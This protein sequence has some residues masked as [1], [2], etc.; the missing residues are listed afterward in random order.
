MKRRIAIW[1]PACL[2][3]SVGT[4][5]ILFIMSD[6]MKDNRSSFLRQFPSHVV[7]EG[8]DYDLGYHS[9]YIAGGTLE[10]IYLGNY[11]S[12]LHL[13]MLNRNLTDTLHIRL[14]VEGVMEQKFWSARVRVDSPYFYMYDGAVPRIY[15]GNTADWTAHRIGYDNEYFLDLEPIG[16]GSFF[17][18]SL[19]LSDES[20]VGKISAGSPHYKFTTGILQKQVDG[21]FCTDGTVSYNNYLAQLVYVYRY[22][23]EFIVMDTN[24]N[25]AY[26]GNTI[27][28][29]THAKINVA[30]IA[31]TNARTFS[32]PPLVV[33][34]QSST[35]K[36]WLFVNSDLLAKNEHPDALKEASVIDVYDLRNSKYSFSFYLFNHLGTEK[37]REFRVVDGGLLV[38]L[39]RTSVK[40]YDLNKEYFPI[41]EDI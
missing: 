11:S 37:L 16:A 32:S 15:K 39:F 35:Y 18:K 8:N 36:N 26:R 41:Q 21:V 12:P 31:S 17:I 34:K 5:A 19:S 23:N 30:T 14:K 33:N 4:V 1:I 40:V 38:A 7:L 3:L 28:T 20:V 24:L 25:V 27:D 29:T 9:Y 2:F 10:Q 13:L 6:I 22:R